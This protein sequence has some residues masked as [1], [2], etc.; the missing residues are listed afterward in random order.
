MIFHVSLRK[1]GEVRIE[2]SDKVAGVKT[3]WE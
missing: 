1:R 2:D 3:T